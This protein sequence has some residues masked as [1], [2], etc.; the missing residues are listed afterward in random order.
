ML[1]WSL[2]KHCSDGIITVEA[3]SGRVSRSMY[4]A[5]C[6]VAAMSFASF[7]CSGEYL[8]VFVC[9]LEPRLPE[10]ISRY[11]SIAGAVPRKPTSFFA[12]SR[13]FGLFE[14]M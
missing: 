11:A 1:P 12:P 6:L 4:W 14:I 7:F 3:K 5:M 9:L 8:A 2:M 10:L 13:F